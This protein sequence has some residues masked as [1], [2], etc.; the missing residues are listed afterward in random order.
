MDSTD[1]CQHGRPKLHVNQE[2][3]IDSVYGHCASWYD[4]PYAG[5]LMSKF[6]VIRVGQLYPEAPIEVSAVVPKAES[7]EP[8]LKVGFIFSSAIGILAFVADM[9][10]NLI[11]SGVYMWVF[12]LLTLLGP[13]LTAVLTR[14]FVWSPASV[15]AVLNEAIKAASTG[16]KK[17]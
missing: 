12:F 7:K 3:Y 5:E 16:N 13:I 4:E 8:A 2:C 1:T 14:G 9:F 15:Q 10:P 11:P 17:S 6:N